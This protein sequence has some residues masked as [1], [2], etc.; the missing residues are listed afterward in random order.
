MTPT[1][2]Q[3]NFYDEVTDGSGNALLSAK[4]G[5]GKTY[6]LV[7]AV[8]LI[9]RNQST[10]ACAFNVSIKDELTSR[11][12]S[13]NADIKTC[14]GLGFSLL[15]GS[16]MNTKKMTE[17]YNFLL[18]EEASWLRSQENSGELIWD[19]KKFTD[20]CRL[21]LVET[22]E[23]YQNC[24]E[25]YGYKFTTDELKVVKRAI[26]L[27]DGDI[28]TIDFVDQ[29]RQPIVRN[30][31]PLFKYDTIWVDETQDLSKAQRELVFKFLKPGGRLFAVGDRSQSIY[32]FSGADSASFDKFSE[33]CKLMSLNTCFRCSKEVIKYVNQIDPDIRAW[34]NAVDGL[35]RGGTTL[36]NIKAGDA[37]L[38]R[39]NAPL[40][41]GCYDM[42]AKGRKATI[43]GKDIGEN[44]INFIVGFK[45]SSLTD[46]Q[47]RMNEKEAQLIDRLEDKFPAEDAYTNPLYIQFS[48]K[49]NCVTT[50]IFKVGTIA[51]VDSLTTYIR[52]IFSDDRNPEILF[53]TVHR[54]KGLEWPNVYII[55]P[56]LLTNRRPKD[57]PWQHEQATNLEYVAYTRAKET[58]NFVVKPKKH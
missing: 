10:L 4:A 42:I 30:L 23:D 40:I 38:C 58:L 52:R 20:L 18:K 46:L 2:E 19:L 5:S 48:E 14:H 25:K 36:D 50:L 33:M 8:S 11:M 39:N 1:I 12:S 9:P 28:K 29:I 24:Q 27:A 49:K 43:M 22:A 54:A 15:R 7:K 37:V 35:V 44:L 17:I 13:T 55:E 32:G 3:Q 16:Q 51:S 34:E 57:Q 56:K 41:D 21:N 26:E 31:N 6:T 45:A 47:R 53:S